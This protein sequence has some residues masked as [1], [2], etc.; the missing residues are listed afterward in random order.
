MDGD[1]I[2]DWAIYQAATLAVPI[3]LLNSILPRRD[4]I[5]ARALHPLICPE[6]NRTCSCI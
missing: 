3:D 4:T 2:I 5:T 6:H 1:E